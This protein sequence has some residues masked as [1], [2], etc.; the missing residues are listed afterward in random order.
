MP[1]SEVVETAPALPALYAERSPITYVDAVDAPLLI[2]AGEND[3]RCPI[4]QVWN[5]VGRLRDRGL[6]PT[7]YTYTTGHSSFDIDERVRQAA[8]V[9]DHLA[10]TVPGIRR[11]D[12]LDAHLA[13]AGVRPAAVIAGT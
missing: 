9:L 5:Y 7:V 3:S 12:G 6:E 1:P 4:R 13:A 10:A 8:I 2:M 11:L